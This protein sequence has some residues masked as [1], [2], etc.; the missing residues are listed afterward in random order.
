MREGVKKDI[1]MIK[2]GEYAHKIDEDTNSTPI[3]LKDSP[4]IDEE[5]Q[6]EDEEP[7]FGVQLRKNKK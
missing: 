1:K 6:K 5:S 3:F 2:Q 4:N 7:A